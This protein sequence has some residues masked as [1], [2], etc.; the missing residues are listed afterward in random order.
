MGW[1]AGGDRERQPVPVAGWSSRRGHR[2]SGHGRTRAFRIPLPPN[3]PTEG[4]LLAFK[5][6]RRPATLPVTLAPVDSRTNLRLTFGL[7]AAI[8][9]SVMLD[10][11]PVRGAR[12]SA[13]L[14]SD[15]TGSPIGWIGN[16]FETKRAAGYSDDEG[17][18]VLTGLAPGVYWIATDQLVSETAL[19]L[20]CQAEIVAPASG[21]HL[22]VRSGQVRIRVFGKGEPLAE[23][24]LAIVDSRGTRTIIPHPSELRVATGL[25]FALEAAQR[26]FVARKVVV[27]PL[28]AGE[29]RDLDVVLEPADPTAI[30]LDLR[31]AIDGSLATVPVD[32][33]PVTRPDQEGVCVEKELRRDLR[34]ERRPDNRFVLEDVP[35]PAATTS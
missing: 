19:G 6:G 10:G 5:P 34:A 9:G 28:T 12:V 1:D 8:E 24:R 25:S 31:G 11:R 20:T 17:R 30:R 15:R 7:G 26:G 23:A 18:F 16:A 33:I 2:R 14:K 32:L 35:Y 22:G 29:R 3:A 27:P 21:V 13:D 4:V